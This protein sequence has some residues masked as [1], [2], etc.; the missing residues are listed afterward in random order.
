MHPSPDVIRGFNF[1]VSFALF[2]M[3]KENDD[4]NVLSC[5][6]QA[7]EYLHKQQEENPLESSLLTVDYFI[8]EN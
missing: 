5:L 1:A 2:V 3:T 6:Q 7:A 4:P 8:K